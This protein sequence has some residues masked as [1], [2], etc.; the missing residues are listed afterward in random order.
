MNPITVAKA[1]QDRYVSY[2]ETSFGLGNDYPAARERFRGAADPPRPTAAR[3]L[4]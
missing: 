4:P 2:L 3:P 1:L